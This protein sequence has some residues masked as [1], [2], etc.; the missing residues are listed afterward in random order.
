MRPTRTAFLAMGALLLAAT[1]ARAT[2]VVDDADKSC[3]YYRWTY[4]P[5]FA[6]VVGVHTFAWGVA[7]PDLWDC[8]VCVPPRMSDPGDPDGTLAATTGWAEMT[9]CL[10]PWAP[11]ETVQ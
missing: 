9:F 8:Q 6:E 11:V 2:G 3:V 10:P 4:A 5:P 1:P 7:N